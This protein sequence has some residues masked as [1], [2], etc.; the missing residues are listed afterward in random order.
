[1]K[2]CFDH[3]K[4]DVYRAAIGFISRVKLIVSLLGIQ[5]GRGLPHSKA[6]PHL[7]D[8]EMPRTQFL[9]QQFS[10]LADGKPVLFSTHPVL[11]AMRSPR[12]FA[13]L[14]GLAIAGQGMR[15]EET[16]SGAEPVVL[17]APGGAARLVLPHDNSTPRL[18]LKSGDGGNAF[19]LIPWAAVWDTGEHEFR[20]DYKGPSISTL[21]ATISE[22]RPVGPAVAEVDY[23]HPD[24]E[25]TLRYEVT[26]DGLTM[27]P[28][29]LL[30]NRD[31][32][33]VLMS[34]PRALYLPVEEGMWYIDGV[35]GGL[36]RNHEAIR[37]GHRFGGA[38]PQATHDLNVLLTTGGGALGSW[39]LQPSDGRTFR[40]THFGLA[41][42]RLESHNQTGLQ[43]GVSCWLAKGEETSL[44]AIRLMQADD[45][46]DLFAAYRRDNNMDDWP[47]LAEKMTPRLAE[48]LPF[49][50]HL[51]AWFRGI[52]RYEREGRMDELFALL[53]PPPVLIEFVASTRE[54]RHDT[55]Y[56]DFLEF[57]HKAGGAPMMKRLIER[58]KERGDLVTMYTH[59]AWW[60]PNSRAVEAMGGPEAL[61]VR[62]RSGEILVQEWS[63]NNGFAVG[64]WREP[65]REFVRDQL[66]TLRD[67]FG[68]DMIFQDQIGTRSDYDFSLDFGKPPHAWMQALFD[69]AG[70]SASVLPVSGEGV[71]PDRAFRDLTATFGFYLTTLQKSRGR[72]YDAQH[73]A[74][75]TVQWPMATMVLHDKVAFYS[76]NLER[77]DATRPDLLRSHV[78]WYLAAGMNMHYTMEE[79]LADERAGLGNQRISALARLQKTVG[80]KF[81]GQPMTRFEFVSYDP[82]V[83]RTEFANGLVILA[84]HDEEP[85]TLR[86]GGIEVEVP[87]HGFLALWK[88]RPL[89]ALLPPDKDGGPPMIADWDPENRRW[90]PVLPLPERPAP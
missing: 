12:G 37:E 21:D 51:K 73:A 36:A 9:K 58:F 46:F 2:T 43:H 10:H 56:P 76:H 86:G 17:T 63:G 23:E 62:G 48:K 35:W 79:V 4:P 84:S 82:E 89:C 67:D 6:V 69:I 74:G 70:M 15:A 7:R 59:P 57:D 20:P 8:R 27:T 13:L 44:P 39:S 26:D 68:F 75:N 49:A 81:F 41:K 19:D 53:P 47:D 16:A 24:I 72:F 77:T 1:M 22:I 14:L 88:G 31:A 5:S 71:G 38:S 34:Y 60:D 18:T 30:N 90:Q 65:V 85:A 50:V 61:A 87:A 45:P 66:T 28:L 11:R 29:R 54:G 42:D 64:V 32:R 78:S 33:L 80:S 25:V 83:T 52:A 55:F 3:E 40:R